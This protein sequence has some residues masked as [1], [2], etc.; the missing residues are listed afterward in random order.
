VGG[1]RVVAVFPAAL[2]TN[3]YLDLLHGALGEAVSV[4]AAEPYRSGWWREVEADVVHLHWLEAIEW[5]EGAATAA[6]TRVR[7]A[8][9]LENLRGLRTRG[10]RVVW[11]VHNLHPHES[12]H[13][14]LD[15]E[16]GRAVIGEVDAV[17]VHSE[18][19]ARRVR[20]ELGEPRALIVAPH[21][22]YGTAYPPEVRARA[23]I[24]EQLGLPADAFV[25]LMFGMLRRYKRVP[26]AA[27]AFRALPDPDA[28]LLIAG[29]PHPDT[30]DEL[31]AAVDGEPRIMLDLEY[32]ADDEVAA[33]HA[34]ADAAVF[35]HAEVFSSGAVILALSY[36]L[37]V[38]IPEAS[39]AG[40]IALPGAA[41][42]F[43]AGELTDALAR[44]RAGD[45]RAAALASAAACT[46]ERTAERVLTA[47]DVRPVT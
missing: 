10:T 40:E 32:V 25:Y 24:R 31:R 21:G 16:L 17:V 42:T 28:R 27:R 7:A 15:A 19:A 1:R 47:Y 4:I 2:G 33:Y 12:R 44:V 35:N 18:F 22:H 26:E 23:W 30:L 9:L 36:G 13:P 11:T 6:V 29:A 43:A 5:E 39:G 8:T 3:P 37:P 41:E 45:R 38:V 14:E 46:W 20:A 34:A